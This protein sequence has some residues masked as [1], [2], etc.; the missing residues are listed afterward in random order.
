MPKETFSHG[1]V[2][3]VLRTC[4]TL[5]IAAEMIKSVCKFRLN[6]IINANYLKRDAFMYYGGV[7]SRPTLFVAQSTHLGYNY[8]R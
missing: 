3:E 8:D 5:R 2:Q 6:T 1:T 4:I 7:W